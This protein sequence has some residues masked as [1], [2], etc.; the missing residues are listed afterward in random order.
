MGNF[1][2]TYPPPP[3]PENISPFD[4]SVV[5]RQHFISAT[6]PALIHK[7]A[8]K[9]S[10][11]LI[12]HFGAGNHPWSRALPSSSS[13][14]L[15]TPPTSLCGAPPVLFL[16]CFCPHLC[17]QGEIVE[18]KNKIVQKKCRLTSWSLRNVVVA[19][20][21]GEIMWVTRP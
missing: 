13:I 8:S 14:C 5:A 20:G 2:V 1:G 3:P 10:K 19:Q 4:H 12:L 18:P 9:S 7:Q 11:S 6:P 17:R 15:L 16:V 21:A